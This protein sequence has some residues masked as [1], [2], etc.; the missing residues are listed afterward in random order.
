M[1]KQMAVQTT[2]L[3]QFKREGKK[4]IMLTACEYSVARVLDEAGVDVLL[5]GDSLGMV[6]LGYDTTVPVTMDEMLHHTRAVVR[7]ATRALV[8]ADMPFMSFQESDQLA[9]HNAGRF[10]KEAGAQAVKLEGGAEMVSRVQA[11]VS[12]GIPVCGHIGLTPQSVHKLGGY[13]VQGKDQEQANRIYKEARLLEEAGAFALV[14]ECVPAELAKQISQDVMI[15]VIGI[16]AGAFCDGQ[17]LVSHDFLGLTVSKTPR[18]VRKY[19][20][21]TIC[22]REAVQRFAED[23]QNGTFPSDEESY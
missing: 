15:P 13:R 20:N 22:I 14:L 5:V 21:L 23:V 6:A 1:S 12:A 7:G 17:V 16:G 10:L 11:V 8:I 2:D 18:F 9:V 19:E 4:I 3:V